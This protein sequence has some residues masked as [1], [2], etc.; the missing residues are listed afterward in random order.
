M[1]FISPQNDFAFKR[2]FGNS[3]HKGVLISFLNAVLDLKHERQ[4]V[5]VEL[6]D[7][8]QVPRLPHLK[9]TLLDVNAIDQCGREF[10]VEMQVE[11][12]RYFHKRALYYN[13]K[14][15]TNQLPRGTDYDKLKK[16]YFIGVLNF[17]ALAG[18]DYLSRHLIL[19]KDTNEQFFNDFE[20]CLIELPKFTKHENDL[21]G[22]VDKWLFFLKY[23]GSEEG[24]D[25]NFESIFSDEPPILEA[26][27]T[28]RFHS[29]S[30]REVRLY[31]YREDRRRVEVEN[32]RT[33]I[34]D[35]HEA[36]HAKG[37]AKGH[38]EG[39]AQGHS[40]GLAKGHSEGR[41]EGRVEGRAEG[42]AEGHA[43]GHSEGLAEGR[44]EGEQIG[45][46]KGRTEVQR[47]TALKL[48]QQGMSVA[49]IAR[50]LDLSEA[51][52]RDLLFG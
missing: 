45:L 39:H 8:Y 49:E 20:F 51:E 6:A 37:H 15:Y 29:M 5:Q 42:R 7:P 50:L 36:G 4:I 18:T 21:Q 19:D 28:A 33:A 11:H 44:A 46:E 38:A 52:L 12:Q 2:I 17:N 43:Q 31:E 16:V 13:S 32:L 10:I 25:K 35:G 34:L 22:I 26:L 23:L 14:A 1:Q 3:E 24:K 27:D 48:Q 9:D 40:E 41:V 30:A 47:Q